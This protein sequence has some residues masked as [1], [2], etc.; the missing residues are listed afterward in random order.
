MIPNAAFF[1]VLNIVFPIKQ[2]GRDGR[3]LKSVQVI[4][5]AVG[6]IEFWYGLHDIHL[7]IWHFEIRC[8]KDQY[9]F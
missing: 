1:L 6:I 5:K 3:N 4:E 8:K 7:E 9:V 2:N